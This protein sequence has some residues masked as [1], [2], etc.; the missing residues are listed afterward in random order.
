[1]SSAT[2]AKL[3]WLDRAARGV[4]RHWLFLLNG[5]VVMYATLPWI[6][7]IAKESG[8]STA[9]DLIFG[10]YKATCH[11]L[12]ERS[13]FIGSSQV[14]Y[15][16]RCTA[17][18]SAIA[19]AGLIYSFVRW[20]RPLSNRLA[21]YAA[22]PIFIDGVWHIANDFLPNLGLRP[23]ANNIGSLNFWLRMATGVLFGL[24]AVMWAYPRLA[25]E[26]DEVQ[27][28]SSGYVSW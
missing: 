6:G 26:L 14:C 10:L 21:L 2:T 18:Y 11:Q 22:V 17:L 19:L 3:A 27:A 8:Y 1:M 9:G 4:L 28:V 15:C 12:P 16:H 25:R 5:A 24:A 7:A 13:F 23:V 20:K